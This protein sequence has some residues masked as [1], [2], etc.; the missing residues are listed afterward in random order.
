MRL[1]G[2]LKDPGTTRA[3]HILLGAPL[4]GVDV[5]ELAAQV[6]AREGDRATGVL[7]LHAAEE[8]GRIPDLGLDLLLTAAE[9][10]VRDDGDATLVA[11]RALEGLAAVVALVLGPV[12]HAVAAPALRGFLPRGQAELLLRQAGQVW[13]RMTQPARTGRGR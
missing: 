2:D 13:A 12:A 5:A 4:G 10:V 8:I 1:I 11:G 6:V 9:I 3:F 7:L